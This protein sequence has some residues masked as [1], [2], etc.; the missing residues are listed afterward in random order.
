MTTKDYNLVAKVLHICRLN[1][2]GK[3]EISMFAQ[4][5]MK[6]MDAFKTDNSRFNKIKFLKAIYKDK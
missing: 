2:H 6:L 1:I 3:N 4:I 5:A